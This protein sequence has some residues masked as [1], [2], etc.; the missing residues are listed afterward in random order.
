MGL[1]GFCDYVL[2]QRH[3]LAVLSD[4]GTITEE[5]SIL[6]FPTLNVREVHEYPEGMEEAA[7]M[8]TGL[9]WE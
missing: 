6:G 7:V 4:S 8:V 5:F 2:L 1:F 9:D 3:A